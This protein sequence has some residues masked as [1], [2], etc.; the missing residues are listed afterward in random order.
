MGAFP[1]S[2]FEV[3]II[4]IN[5]DAFVIRIISITTPVPQGTL[6]KGDGASNSFVKSTWLPASFSS[7]AATHK[8]CSV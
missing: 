8:E 6:H 5:A 1:A 4:D 2:A 7:Q 3:T